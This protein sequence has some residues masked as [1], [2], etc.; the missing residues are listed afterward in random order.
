MHLTN[1]ETLKLEEFLGDG[2]P[3]YAVLSHT[4]GRDDEEI[5]FRDIRRG[6]IEKAGGQP[7]KF[8]E[9]YKQAKKDGLGYAWTDTCCINKD[10]SRKLDEPINS[11][12]QWYEKAS[13]CYAYL[14]DVFPGD[15]PQDS[16][17]KFSSSRW[18][19]RG[20]TLQEL[21]APKQLRFYDLTWT[22]IGKRGICPV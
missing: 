16:N 7:I 15:N 12:F 22:F 2:V 10:S 19:R 8:K 11:M 21:L 5:S 4:W 14:S 9:C 17:S 13:I 1:L 3:P 6:C 18:F 20:W